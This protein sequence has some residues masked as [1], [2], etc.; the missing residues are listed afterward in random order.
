[1]TQK[2]VGREQPTLH[3]NMAFKLGPEWQEKANQA[4][5]QSIAQRGTASA[6]APRREKFGQQGEQE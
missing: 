4:R 3:K 5:E 2:E 1:M 6:K